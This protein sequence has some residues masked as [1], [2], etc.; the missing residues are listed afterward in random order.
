MTQAIIL[1]GGFGTRLRSAIG[2]EIPKPMAPIAEEPFLAHYMRYLQQQG[3]TEAVLSVHHLR[4]TIMSYFGARFERINIMYAEEETPLGTGGAVRYALSILRPSQPVL[5]V[6]GDTFTALDIAAVTEAH[7]S[8]GATLTIALTRMT[9]CSR[10]GEVHFNEQQRITSFRYPGAPEPGWISTGSY[11]VSPDIFSG[12]D[13]PPAFSFEADFQRPFCARVAPRAWVA[14]GYF[15]DIG[16]PED[17]AR[18]QT[19]LLGRMAI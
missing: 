12:F 17:Y 8:S 14:D 10:Y 6:N 9:D 15:I 13:L 3:V 7:R 2:A 19:E 16:V 5:V 18:A 1:A 11:V 4:E